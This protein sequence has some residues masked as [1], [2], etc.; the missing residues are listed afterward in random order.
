MPFQ[1]KDFHITSKEPIKYVGSAMSD[2]Q[3][4]PL[5]YDKDGQ[6]C[7]PTSDWELEVHKN[8]NGADSGISPKQNPDEFPKFL[9]KKEK[10]IERS[11]EMGEN[12]L[13]FSFDFGRLCPKEGEF[14]E[15]LMGE[16]VQA[17]AMIKARGNEPMVT[18]NHFTMPKFL[19]GTDEN[20]DITNGGWENP[21]VAKHFRFYIENVTRFLADDDKVRAVLS[22]AGLDKES[23]DRFL[24][25]GLVKYFISIN[26]PLTVCG[27]G[28]LTGVF[29]P[30]KRGRIILVKK[31][32]E[33]MVEAHDITRDSL[34]T[35]SSRRGGDNEPQVG[36]SYNWNHFDGL[37][38]GVA[39]SLTNEY[40]TDAFERKG[41]QSDFLGL[42]YYFRM[43]I[44]ARQSKKGRE[45]G[46]HPGFGDI[47]PPGILEQLRKMNDRYPKKEIFI[48]EMGFADKTDIRKP[49][50][51]LETVRYVLEAKK[52]GVPIR[53]MLL[54][55][56][57]N[58]LE[59]DLGMD[60]K[61]GLFDEKDLDHPLVAGTEGIRSWE[62]WK[63]VTK[64]LIKPT[65]ESFAELQAMY[66]KAK[67][68]SGE[69]AILTP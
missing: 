17:L 66:E 39:H 1:E 50:W 59:W 16:Y 52:Q 64:A 60:T 7:L 10:Y 51:I 27:N 62:A 28:Y 42:Q 31:V 22:G 35:L 40:V 24:S 45:Y 18:I 55:S 32:L 20:N 68:Q 56:L 3:A 29:P 38:G 49:Y 15:S 9:K 46:D 43:S 30:Y 26:E 36:A 2:F 13:R 4:E 19:V 14:N 6:L 53:G 5:F 33:R 37:L 57:V 69:S 12:M 67:K 47:Y 63:A 11:D 21:E 8:I 34:K 41:A 44:L 65:S 25:E 58:N 48:T 23:Q 54:W 61:F